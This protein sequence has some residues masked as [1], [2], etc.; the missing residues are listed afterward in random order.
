MRGQVMDGRFGL[1]RGDLDQV[2]FELVAQDRNPTDQTAQTRDPKP[3]EAQATKG[4][5]RKPS[6]SRCQMP[7]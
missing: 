5:T 3:A 6:D 2:G 1:D 4:P 7:N